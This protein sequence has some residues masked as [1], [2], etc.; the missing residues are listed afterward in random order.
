M[1][2]Q[3]VSDVISSLSGSHGPYIII[4]DDLIV[5]KLE[6]KLRIHHLVSHLTDIMQNAASSKHDRQLLKLN[7]GSLL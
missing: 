7:L 5:E 1:V 3:I 6:F 4:G 2:Q